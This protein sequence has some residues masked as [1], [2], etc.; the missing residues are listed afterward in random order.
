MALAQL[1]SK[2]L[3]CDATKCMTTILMLAHIAK[4]RISANYETQVYVEEQI[5]AN[6]FG[7]MVPKCKHYIYS[8]SKDTHLLK[9]SFPANKTS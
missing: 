2:G 7:D 5:E 8:N 9:V 6:L 1:A 3:E 4:H